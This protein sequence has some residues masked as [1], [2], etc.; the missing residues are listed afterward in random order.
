MKEGRKK[1]ASI[2]VHIIIIIYIQSVLLHTYIIH[3][4]LRV[5]VPCHIMVSR[6]NFMFLVRLAPED[7]VPSNM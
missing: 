6:C 7:S 4:C 1:E 3:V 2:Y 5:V